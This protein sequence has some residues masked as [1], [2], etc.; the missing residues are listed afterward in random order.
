MQQFTDD[1]IFFRVIEGPKESYKSISSRDISGQ[2]DIEL[3]ANSIQINKFNDIANLQAQLEIVQAAGPERA[4][5]MPLIRDLLIKYENK[6]V[7]EIII[8]EEE[9]FLRKMA[10]DPELF[11]RMQEQMI[12]LQEQITGVP[13]QTGAVPP[14]AQQPQTPQQ[15]Q[16]G[17]IVEQIIA[18]I[19]AFMQA[20]QQFQG[21]AAPQEVVPQ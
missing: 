11:A 5:I 8:P 19:P 10:N 12:A 17:G 3:M 7:N 13:A 16:Q 4:D 6:S 15:V 18:G 9:A 1:D 21:Q 14:T 20:F 2:Y